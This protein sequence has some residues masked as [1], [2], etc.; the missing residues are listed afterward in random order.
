MPKL[1]RQSWVKFSRYLA[2][3]GLIHALYR[4]FRYP[5]IRLIS[6]YKLRKICDSNDPRIIFE[7]IY[8]TNWW[9][10]KESISG[11]GS[12]LAYTESLREGLPVL[13]KKYAVKRVFDAP[14]GDFNWMRSVIELCDVEYFGGDIVPALIERNRTQY[15]LRGVKFGVMNL[16][17]DEFPKADIWICRDCLIHFSYVDMLQTFEN[18]A[19]SNI[20]YFLTTTH[21]NHGHFENKDIR[22]GDARL[23]DL[24]SEPFL[25]TRKYLDAIDDWREPD[26]PRMMVLFT[27]QQ[28]IDALPK[29]RRKLIVTPQPSYS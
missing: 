6:K 22:T 27:R 29:M 11:T 23:I 19:S 21:T 28:I 5:A 20:E 24:F 25:L 12:T 9:G 17:S 2:T 13:I 10:E 1:V 14:C 15:Q 16:M 18:F 7:R 4:A 3:Y 26:H 8:N